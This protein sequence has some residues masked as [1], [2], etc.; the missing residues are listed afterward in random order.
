MI[1]KYRLEVLGKTGWEVAFEGNDYAAYFKAVF[2]A[3]VEGATTRATCMGSAG[4]Q[5][6]EAV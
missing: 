5:P 1:G 6:P 4:A 2:H 3:S